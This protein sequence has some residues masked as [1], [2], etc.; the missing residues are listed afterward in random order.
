MANIMMFTLRDAAYPT[1]LRGIPDAPETLYVRGMR[2]SDMPPM[3][4]IVGSRTCTEYGEAAAYKLGYELAALGFV[5]VSG[6]AS[7]VD[8][9]AHRGAL[10]AG[11]LTVAVLGCGSDICYP[12][13][14]IRLM[15]DILQQ[16]AIVSEYPAGTSS[17]AYRFPRRNRIISGLS[18]GLIVVEAAIKSGTQT[19]VKHAQSQGR[20]I[21][22]VPGGIFSPRS[23][24][25]N[26]LI[27]QGA[28][29][30]TSGRDA[31]EYLGITSKVPVPKAIRTQTPLPGNMQGAEAKLIAHINQ[32]AITVDELALATGLPVREVLSSLAMLEIKGAI[33]QT[34]GQRYVRA[35]GMN[36]H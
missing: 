25:T 13:E 34:Q 36:L 20:K 2:L 23:G 8:S 35:D 29:L 15:E 19:T 22:A 21:M 10:D 32:T 18:L 31:A 30:V 11:G 26:E 14:N 17:Q 28:R 1:A 6:M 5:V 12:R 24:G 4:A 7:G 33:R 16:G 3:V 9:R 27:R